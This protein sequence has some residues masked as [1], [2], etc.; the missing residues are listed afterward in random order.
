MGTY[1]LGWA[2]SGR[3]LHQLSEDRHPCRAATPFWQQSAKRSAVTCMGIDR[4][5]NSSERHLGVGRGYCSLAWFKY[6]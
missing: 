3:D 4:G 5:R 6:T 1:T 2:A